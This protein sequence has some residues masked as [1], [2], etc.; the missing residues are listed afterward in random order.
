[1]P[2][3]Q[4]IVVVLSEVLKRAKLAIN[5]KAYQSSC[6]ALATRPIPEEAPQS[7]W[8]VATAP[9]GGLLGV[10]QSTSYQCLSFLETSFVATSHPS[11]YC[12]AHPWVDIFLPYLIPHTKPIASFHSRIYIAN[13]ISAN[14]QLLFGCI[15]AILTFRNTSYA[16]AP[17][18]V[19]SLRKFS[20]ALEAQKDSPRR[21]FVNTLKRVVLGAGT[22][23]AL[24]NNAPAFAEEAT[25]GRIVEMQVANLGG[26]EGKT[27]TVRIQLRPEWAPRGVSRFEVRSLPF[28]FLR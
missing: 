7:T 5:R 13:M 23:A 17:T 3:Q 2:N 19:T 22:A 14:K 12:T 28:S 21:D 1:M 6:F 18:I 20:T 24:K 11:L 15:V 27:G 4:S 9:Y 10:G 8:Y 26:E 25:T 16:F